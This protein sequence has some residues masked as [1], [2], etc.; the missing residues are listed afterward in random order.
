LTQELFIVS[1]KMNGLARKDVKLSD[2]NFL[3]LLE[4]LVV[5]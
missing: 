1:K 5:L 3:R 2:K 4:Y